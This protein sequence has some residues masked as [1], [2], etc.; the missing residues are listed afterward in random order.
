LVLLIIVGGLVVYGVVDLTVRSPSASS[1]GSND[2]VS[3]AMVWP[4]GT[5]SAN[6]SLTLGQEVRLSVQVPPSS[7]PASVHQVVNGQVYGSFDWNVTATHYDY[8]IDSGP[9]DAAD[10]GVNTAYAVVTF[11]DGSTARSANVTYTVV[12]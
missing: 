4:N 3:A 1:T 9:A 8:V 11:A 5:L 10:L 12:R 7:D 2:Q 6:V